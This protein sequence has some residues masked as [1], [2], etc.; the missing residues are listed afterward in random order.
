MPRYF[1]NLRSPEGFYLDIEGMV[2]S[3]LNQAVEQ[4]QVAAELAV[5]MADGPTQG[6]FEIEDGAR[7]L[8]AT[9]PFRTPPRDES[10]AIDAASQ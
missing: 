9:V 2:L 3:S 10:V 8:Q 1:F 4:A 7:V 6:V 5:E